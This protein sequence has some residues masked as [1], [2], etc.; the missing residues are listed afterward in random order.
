MKAV[1]IERPHRASYVDVERPHAR[2][3]QVIVRVASVGICMSD[4]ELLDGTRPDQ[5]VRYP[6]QPGHEWCGTI[7]EL[8]PNVRGMHVG[9]RVAVEGHNFC[10]TCFWCVRGDTNLCETY[11]EFGF[12]LP[13]GYA[14]YVAVRA[15]LAHPFSE[16]VSYDV[17]AL[18]E[19]AA[20]AGH[21]I[22]R[23]GIHPG[24]IV[25]VIGPGTIGL[26]ALAWARL[27]SPRHAIVIGRS[28]NN[29]SIARAVGATHYLTTADDALGLVREL[30]GGRGADVV[31]EATG[32][33]DAV[34]LAFDAARRGGVVI[35][36]GISG[37]PAP[38]RIDSDVFCLKDLRVHGIF[39]YA[40]RHFVGALHA[41]ESG[42]L[43]V[44]PLITHRFPLSDYGRAFELL[45]NRRERVVKVVLNP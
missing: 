5:Y 30:S 29:E 38:T 22:M 31:V 12:T 17:A 11:S 24:D 36:E 19:P 9:Q 6:V 18:T 23:A 40:S 44:A 39:A 45:K 7:A 15:D 25:A 20:C 28:S 34:P 13:G 32:N 3:G 43:N 10:R 1:V 14:E 37:S 21:G 41:I 4:V 42:L 16:S 33:R 27:F 35:L 8:G 26:L 2:D